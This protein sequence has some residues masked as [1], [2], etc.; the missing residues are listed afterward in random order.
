MKSKLFVYALLLAMLFAAC[1]AEQPE[2]VTYNSEG[3][4]FS[5][6]VPGVMQETI[7]DSDTPLGMIKVHVFTLHRGPYG[8]SVAYTDYPV[9]HA[10]EANPLGA[11]EGGMR[12]TLDSVNATLLAKKDVALDFVPGIAFQGEFLGGKDLD[13]AAVVFGRV[14]L[15]ETRLYQLTV[16]ARKDQVEAAQPEKFLTSFQWLRPD[17]SLIDA[18][19]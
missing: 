13:T 8:Y 12:R 10:A 14:Y 6:T 16:V 2:W 19:K 4:N 17:E 15:R 18:M 9:P 3:G 5:V 7:N 11:L 1:R